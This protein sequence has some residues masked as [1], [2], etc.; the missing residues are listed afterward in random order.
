MEGAK[1]K[2]I[3]AKPLIYKGQEYPTRYLMIVWKDGHVTYT[4]ETSIGTGRYDLIITDSTNF[5]E[6][7]SKQ[8]LSLKI[9]LESRKVKHRIVHKLK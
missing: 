1:K 7:I 5:D 6:M 2:C 9:A 4:A 3:G 8:K